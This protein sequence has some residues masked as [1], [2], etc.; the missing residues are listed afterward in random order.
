MRRGEFDQNP[1]A[2]TAK[3]SIGTA[4]RRGAMASCALVN[5]AEV[6]ARMAGQCPV[7]TDSA[8]RSTKSMADGTE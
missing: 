5:C 4:A 6:R 3:G 7:A 1:V 8:A 2:R